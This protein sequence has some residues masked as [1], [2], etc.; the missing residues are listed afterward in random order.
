[1]FSDDSI[2]HD[3]VDIAA[4]EQRIHEPLRSLESY[5][6]KRRVQEPEVILPTLRSSDAGQVESRAR[7]QVPVRHP[8]ADTA[9]PR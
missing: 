3:H 7:L 9:S 5:V 8:A 4:I 2:A 6:K 1:M